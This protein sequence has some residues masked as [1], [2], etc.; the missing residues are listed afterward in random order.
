MNTYLKYQPAGV[1]FVAFLGL[2][3]GFFLINMLLSSFFFSDLSMVMLDKGA[4]ITP[5][6]TNQFK[7]AQLTSSIL[8][9]IVPALLFGYFSSPKVFPYI[10]I[11][12][13]I[14]VVLALAAIVFLFS[15][16]PFVGWLGNLNAKA[17]FGSFQKSFLET[18]AMYNRAINAFLKMNS[19]GDLLINLF[20]MALLPAIGEELFFRGALQKMLYRLCNMGWLAILVSAAIFALLHGTVFKILPIFVLGLM[21]GTIYHLTRNLWYGIIIHFLN[22]AF[23]VFAVYYS[24]KSEMMKKLADENFTVPIYAALLSLL[25]GAAIIYFM[26]RKSDEVLPQII[27]NEDNDYIA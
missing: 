10:G 19:V 14:S 25:A 21:L 16:Q 22:N 20:I 12:K 11:Q 17:N 18:E 24:T 2:A 8:I 27:T 15:V 1:Q 23:A 26:K 6:L 5:Q 9:F 3:T 4:T 7:L 13:S